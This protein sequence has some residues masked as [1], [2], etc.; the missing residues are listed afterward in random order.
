M[1]T[2]KERCAALN[3]QIERAGL[4]GDYYV[5]L[6]PRGYSPYR[7]YHRYDGNKWTN[8][9]GGY[10]KEIRAVISRMTYA[11]Y[12]NRA[13]TPDDIYGGYSVVG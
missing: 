2:N 8:I 11:V 10:F 12:E 13:I 1:K 9:C 5:G 7:M 3:R 6:A 4:Q